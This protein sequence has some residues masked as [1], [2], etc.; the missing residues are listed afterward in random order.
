MCAQRYVQ[1]DYIKHNNIL[2]T[3]TALYIKDI[4]IPFNGLSV[5]V[6][7]MYYVCIVCICED[8]YVLC[9]YCLYR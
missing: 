4:G 8:Y 6:K 5:Y 7:I 1:Y 2:S 9:M 3:Q